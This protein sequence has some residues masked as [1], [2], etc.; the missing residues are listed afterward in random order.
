M[1]TAF[2]LVKT[3]FVLVMLLLFYSSQLLL[4]FLRAVCLQLY[5]ASSLQL[6]LLLTRMLTRAIPS[7]YYFSFLCYRCCHNRCTLS[8]LLVSIFVLKPWQLRQCDGLTPW[9]RIIMQKMVAN[10]LK[11]CYLSLNM[12]AKYAIVCHTYF[13]ISHNM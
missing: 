3:D 7:T 8:S 13:H 6:L 9:G 4:T 11:F 12:S 1:K 10:K 5:R 2:L